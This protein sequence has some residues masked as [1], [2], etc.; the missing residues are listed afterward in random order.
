M[1]IDKLVWLSLIFGSSLAY[2]KIYIFHLIYPI[3]LIK[4]LLKKQLKIPREIRWFYILP[5]YSIL[6]LIWSIDKKETIKHFYYLNIGILI[7]FFIYNSSF[8]KLNKYINRLIIFQLI[9][10]LLETLNILRW[11]LSPYSKLVT[12][13]GREYAGYIGITDRIPTGFF[14]NPN[15]L[16]CFL[17][18]VL[19]FYLYQKMWGLSLLIAYIIIKTE[20]RGATLSLI[21]LIVIFL[22][23]KLKSRISR[24]LIYLI[25]VIILLFLLFYYRNILKVI[26][27]LKENPKNSIEIR[28]NLLLNCFNS[29]KKLKYFL[30]GSGV[31]SS[32]RIHIIKNNTNGVTNTH[33]FILDILIEYGIIIFTLLTINLIKIYKDNKALIKNIK[34][35]EKRK[36]ISKSIVL[37]LLILFP[38]SISPSGLIYF[39]PLWILLGIAIKNKRNLDI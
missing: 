27:T 4:T 15:N 30:I 10:S 39:F 28:G 16:G 1:I 32:Q 33:L 5:L 3:W 26:F 23:D 13:F 12:K 7:M 11:P 22:V 24:K 31:G 29:L 34:I 36:R 20:S 25:M 17:V 38:A 35:S 37:S 6:S 14:G 18:M 9:I 8:K 21:I 2:G 19:P